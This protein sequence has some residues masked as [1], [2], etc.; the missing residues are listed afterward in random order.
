MAL[1][2]L[3]LALP[4]AT[5]AEVTRKVADSI[6]LKLNQTE[7]CA[8]C[9]YYGTEHSTA[10]MINTLVIAVLV[11]LGGIWIY[12]SR[13]KIYILILAVLVS[14]AVAGSYFAAPYL[15][16]DT[17]KVPENCP[18]IDK[19]N[20]SDVF[21]AP[22]QDEFQSIQPTASYKK[23]TLKTDSAK[24]TAA[25]LPPS[26]NSSG[27]ASDEF[28]A[29]ASGDEF[30]Q[31][32][33][34]EFSSASHSTEVKEQPQKINRTMIIEPAVIFLILGLI[35]YLIKYNW[36]RKTRAF[37]LI[38]SLI[39]LGFVRG[40]CPCMISSF[41]NSVLMIFGVPVA[42]ESLLWFLA[43]IPA[44]YFFGK[45][46]CGWL[47][48]LGAFQEFIHRVSGVNFLSGRKTQKTLK[49]IQ[50]SVIV[51]WILQLLVT[52]T[53][54]FCEYDPFKVAFNLL[55]PSWV[56]WAL[57]AV[58][59][60]SSLLM[61]RPF[62]RTICPVGLILGWVSRIPGAKKL[63]KDTTCI[64]CKMCSAE[65]ATKAMIYENK[66]TTLNNED[67]IMCGECMSSCKTKDALH[68]NRKRAAK[69][70]ISVVF[71][72]LFASQSA[73]AQ[74]ECPSRLGATLK[75]IGESNL[76]WASELT[77][78]GGFIGKYKVANL[79]FYTGLDFSVNHHTLYVEGGVKN[80]IRT[81]SIP[82]VRGNVNFNSQK[83]KFGLREAFYRYS[84]DK[85]KFILGLSSTKSDDYY[86]INER[87]IGANY[88][89]TFGSFD[90]NV[91]GGSVLKQVARN[92]TFCTVGYLINVVPGRK[93]ALIGSELGQT[94]VSML[95]LTYKPKSKSE[96]ENSEFSNAEPKKAVFG[97]EEV[98]GLAYYEF[99]SGVETTPFI[100]GLYSTI[101][102]AGFKLKPEVLYQAA[103]NNNAVLYNAELSKDIEWKNG[104]LTKAFAR[105]LGLQEI[106]KNAIALNSY[107]NVFA[108]EVLRLDALELPFFQ[109]GIKHSFPKIKFSVKLQGALQTGKT[110]GYIADNLGSTPVPMKELDLS[111]SK[112]FGKYV[113]INA[114]VGYIEHP[115][116]SSEG[117]VLAYK[118][119]SSPWGKV[120]LRLTF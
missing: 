81:D 67:C 15:F 93:R 19:K 13:K 110:L 113:L 85:N 27:T 35:G 56:G 48:H 63:N 89:V 90:L 2:A 64:N 80:W 61:H 17:N 73:N 14:G 84:D 111:L 53:N 55:S 39:Y 33:N 91:L 25:A 99:G 118:K 70:A 42:W 72:L 21:S 66:I 52:R 116:L 107:S 101:N 20:H 16:R 69:S 109:A 117:S 59:I 11:L 5:Y 51:L 114:Y 94:N 108:G 54:I 105:Y 10:G 106:S 79:M 28:T 18:V 65:C 98:G 88:K 76:M 45:V 119:D 102:L 103:A 71:L 23:D 46:W 37:F 47:C 32:G 96:F 58:L 62:C 112:N 82:Y 86:L 57:L 31:A 68:V 41:Q 7:N 74:W 40:A 97:L 30:S 43:L 8:T 44:T 9:G 26:N 34:E 4:F 77:T 3:M 120:E 6:A 50:I 83:L 22:A 104:Q 87:I 49:I 95:S 75:P 24:T 12:S 1:P 60:V 36:F 92:G 100:T 38:G 78:S 115:T 29:A